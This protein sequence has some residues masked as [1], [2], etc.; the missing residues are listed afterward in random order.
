[1][2]R[3]AHPLCE[4]LN[5]YYYTHCKFSSVRWQRICV[6]QYL[7]S[8][9]PVRRVSEFSLPIR[10]YHRRK[11]P[12]RLGQFVELLQSY[13]DEAE[14]IRDGERRGAAENPTKKPIAVVPLTG[15][16]SP[17][18]PTE[19][20]C[21]AGDGVDFYWQLPGAPPHTTRGSGGPE[22]PRAAAVR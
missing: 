19:T 8:A 21:M 17:F 12:S 7:R 16:T 22:P 13:G 15:S 20:D 2:F 18:P 6:P 11:E 10:L 4:R 3:A 14:Q 5:C 1:L 9:R